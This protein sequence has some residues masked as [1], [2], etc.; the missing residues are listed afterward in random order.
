MSNQMPWVVLKFGGTS[1]SS[2]E[3]WE[4][5][6]TVLRERLEAG[7]RPFLV[8]SAISGVSNMLEE[9][10]D[11]AR[12]G[13]HE[14]T[15]EALRERHR[16]VGDALE[17]DWEEAISAEF[18][19]LQRLAMGA[20]LTGEVSPR[21]HARV[22]SK[23]ELML[24]RMAEKFL[25]SKGLNVGWK[26]ARTLL[27][28]IE[29]PGVHPQRHFLSAACD[30]AADPARS[31]ELADEG[32]DVLLTQGFI[33]S[34]D[35][36]ETVLLGRGGSDTSAAY[37]AAKFG[38][39]RLEIWTDVP[40]MY[41]ANPRQVPTA[42]LLKQLLYD[43]A[44]E[45]ATMG[46]KV[47]HPRCIDP[48]RRSS[49]P[50]QI[51]CTQRPEIEGTIISDDTPDFGAQVKAVSAK[52]GI[53]LVSMDTVGMWQ[54]VG[55]LAD[56]FQAFKNRGLSVD[57]VATSETNVTVSLDPVANALDDAMLDSLVR[58]LEPYCEARVIG[59]C[60]AVSLV[61]QNIR[62]ILHQL[63]QPLEA[64]EEQRI[65]LVSQA[66]S[67]LNLTF[68]V[69]EENASKLVT[70]LHRMVFND[71]FRDALLGP[72]WKELFEEGKPVKTAPGAWWRE[73]RDDLIELV[74]EGP[75][76][77]YD[78]GTLRGRAREV[79]EIPSL[80]RVFYAVK[81]NPNKAVLSVLKEEGVG[82]ECVSPGELEHVR[83][84]FPKLDPSRLLYTPNF[85]P[86]A[87]YEL[88]FEAGAT[89]TLDNLHPLREW[90]DVFAGK[91]IMVRID[92]G[93]GRG[94]HK[95]VKTA[96][97]GSKFGIP[98]IDFPEL[99]RLVDA[100][101]IEVVGLHSHVGS[102]IREPET[103]WETAK[104]LGELAREFP[105]VRRLNLGGGLGVPEK[106]GQRRLDLARV[107]E[108]LTAFRED[109]PDFELWMEPGRYLVAEAGVL[110]A[111]C[112]Q[113]KTKSAHHHYVGLEVG[114][115]ALI[116]PALYGAYHRIV[117]LSRLDQKNA[118]TADVVGPIC[119]TGDVLGHRR[120][121]P[122]TRSGDVFLIDT[123]GA[124][125]F[126][127]SSRYNL[128]PPAAEHL[129]ES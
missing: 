122:E 89:V 81:A 68:V 20:S 3:R 36:G 128:R 119:E 65:Y 71:R 6:T 14:P 114:M 105:S 44:Q 62:A 33:A 67:D 74:E 22:M 19:E 9:L 120:R 103:W 93:R 35:A 43:E 57:L 99:E 39:Q 96:G 117:N 41:T 116:R 53:L 109:H 102:G 104:Y 82:F 98:P 27:R 17:I 75:A 8:C 23:G 86:R 124:Y 47:L 121:L 59:P 110:V 125:G 49:I 76:Y 126:A 46:A 64:F 38:A 127:M 4:V 51:R 12:K 56:V 115:N 63:G 91:Q 30:F 108:L 87:D 69:D 1:V 123:A 55:F 29:E 97:P 80:D 72:T 77:V 58:D 73:R 90:P 92:P 107:G 85:A 31:R 13:T 28:S 111:R 42:R 112:T 100:H 7:A 70:K 11:N 95:F 21:L 16:E 34:D 106:P 66:A 45:L 32:L 48:V 24:T 40:G 113:L 88:G 15:I 18:D 101:D 10:L 50:L 26:D 118:I 94:H 54:Q 61:G 78:E 25:E 37:F 5:I 52:N 84:L 60:A 79:L 129:L 83:D 2:R